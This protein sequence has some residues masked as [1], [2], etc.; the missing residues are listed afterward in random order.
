[1]L[2]DLV[3]LGFGIPYLLLNLLLESCI[4]DVS[5]IEISYLMN[6][7]DKGTRRCGQVNGR[8]VAREK[9]GE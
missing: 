5:L 9:A 8:Y 4:L 6:T 7:V 2:L 1:M 3:L